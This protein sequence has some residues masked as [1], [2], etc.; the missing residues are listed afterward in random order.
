VALSFGGLRL[1]DMSH[2][3][4]SSV[5]ADAPAVTGDSGPPDL[6]PLRAFPD[7]RVVFYDVPGTDTRAISDYMHAHGLPDSRDNTVGEGWTQWRMHWHSPP[8]PGGCDTAAAQVTFSAEITLPRFVDFARMDPAH[9]AGWNRYLNALITHE[10]GHL[11][12][13]YQHV[14]DVAAAIRR[15][16]CAGAE[17]AG[18]AAISVLG[19]YDVAYDAE[20]H[21]GQTQGVRYPD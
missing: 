12:H 6:T 5:I 9:Q 4:H 2:R 16:P 7:T 21:H 10:A 8:A 13:A 18:Q 3:P 1:L 11:G 15:G 20:T 17:A 14:G 19:R